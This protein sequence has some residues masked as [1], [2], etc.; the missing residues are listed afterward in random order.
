MTTLAS[1]WQAVSYGHATFSVYNFVSADA[2]HQ[3]RS[4]SPVEDIIAEH[5]P[6][7]KERAAS[8][9]VLSEAILAWS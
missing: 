5:E 9:L 6:A 8:P 1:G 7:A 2:D 4:T 3:V